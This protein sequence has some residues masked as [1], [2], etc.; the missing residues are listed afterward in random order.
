[1]IIRNSNVC[2]HT[3]Q[4]AKESTDDRNLVTLSGTPNNNALKLITGFKSTNHWPKNTS[5]EAYFAL[6][7]TNLQMFTYVKMH[8]SHKS[9]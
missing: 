5:F 4:G 2:C 7:F 8:K 6:K 1:M 3:A 9:L